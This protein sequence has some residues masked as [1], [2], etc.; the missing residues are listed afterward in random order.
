MSKYP[1]VYKELG[2]VR[3]RV[4]NC[5]NSFIAE[6]LQYSDMHLLG[7]ILERLQLLSKDILMNVSSTTFMKKMLHATLLVAAKKR[8]TEQIAIRPNQP[9]LANCLVAFWGLKAGNM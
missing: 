5:E 8:S 7:M 2:G 9:I 4:G 1:L 3:G 6:N